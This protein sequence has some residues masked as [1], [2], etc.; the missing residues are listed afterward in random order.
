MDPKIEQTQCNIWARFDAA[1]E[2]QCLEIS[3]FRADDLKITRVHDPQWTGCQTLL[4]T[5]I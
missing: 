5:G 4:L 1:A 3:V 2:A